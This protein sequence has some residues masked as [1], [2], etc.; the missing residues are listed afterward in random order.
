MMQ[1]FFLGP[2]R[3][4]NLLYFLMLLILSFGLTANWERLLRCFQGVKSGVYLEG[5]AIAGL[6]PEEVTQIVKAMAIQLKREP[7]NAGYYSE[8]GQ[9]MPS[10]SGREVDVVRNVNRVYS[11][12]AGSRLSLE[13]TEIPAA[14]GADY[15]QAVYHGD[16][17]KSRVAL[18]INV[19]WGEEH[20]PEILQVLQ[21][22]KVH[23]TFFLVGSWV[24]VF[25]ELVKQMAGAGHEMANHGLYHGHPLQMG[26]ADV[27]KLI[28]D[29]SLLIWS[30][31]GKKPANL[32]APPYGEVN[33]TVVNCAAELG[34]HTV[35][36]S[37]DSVDWK[38][39]AP[40]MMLQR[41]TS[42]IQPGGIILLH[43]TLPTKMVLTG[44]I[45]S[46]RQKGLEPGTVTSVL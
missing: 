2:N 19:A 21:S 3:L 1:V 10:Q 40:D 20:L 17:G 44:L 39:P 25:P 8:T 4:R 5:R 6:L 12:P 7:L 9:I 36:W 23:V 15:Y 37:V 35:L 28:A 11:A 29:N 33:Q 27:K 18:A 45:K 16:T 41:I 34:Y 31:T 13:V 43:P 42:K 26:K 30:V 32:F 22:E 24:K 38:N 46:L 14:I